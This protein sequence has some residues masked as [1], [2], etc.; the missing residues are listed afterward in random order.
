[1]LRELSETNLEAIV[2]EMIA[3][4]I[5]PYHFASNP[6]FHAIMDGFFSGLLFMESVEEIE[7]WCNSFLTVFS[8]FGESYVVVVNNIK[9]QLQSSLMNE[10]G[11]SF[12]I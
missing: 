12:N 8:S 11:I 3:A 5:V 6:S 10:F 7:S 1:M 2:K 4:T 9:K